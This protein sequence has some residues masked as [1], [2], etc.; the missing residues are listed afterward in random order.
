MGHPGVRMG[1][2]EINSGIA[3]VT[4]PWII[5]MILGM[6]RTI[7]LTLSGRLMDADECHRIGVIHHLVDESQVLERSLEIARELGAKPP[8]AMRLDKQRF[9]EM[10]EASFRETIDAAIRLHKESYATGEPQRM[11]EA[12]FEKRKKS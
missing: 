3:S 8:V 5:D 11:M 10:T 12:F 2:P 7:E 4:G 9:K 1:Q 6:S